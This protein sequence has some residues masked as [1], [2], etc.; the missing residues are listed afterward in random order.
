MK[1]F[2]QNVCDIW[3]AKHSRPVH[4]KIA[5]LETDECHGHLDTLWIT[6]IC[7]QY[8]YITNIGKKN[9]FKYAAVVKPLP[10]M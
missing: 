9:I 10:Y 7:L 1:M 2:L 5:I 8:Q 4:N 3:K 6:I